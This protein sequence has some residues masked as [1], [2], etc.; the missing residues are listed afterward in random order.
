MNKK[1]VPAKNKIN[2]KDIQIDGNKLLSLFWSFSNTKKIDII[3][4]SNDSTPVGTESNPSKEF[5]TV[6]SIIEIINIGIE[7]FTI[8]FKFLLSVFTHIKRVNR[9]NSTI[10]KIL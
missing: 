8:L 6:S 9:K 7:N 4:I 5:W 2:P 10:V 1:N 3:S